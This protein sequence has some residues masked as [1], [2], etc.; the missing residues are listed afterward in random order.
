MRHHLSIVSLL[1]VSATP[2]TLASQGHAYHVARR[3]A[4]PGD[5]FWDYLTIDTASRRLYVTHGTRVQVLDVD[6][7]TVIG[8]IPNTPGVHDVALAPELGRGFTSNGRAAS[9]TIF[10]LKTL[11]IIGTVAVPGG[12]P[13][14]IVYDSVSRRVFTFNGRSRTATAIDAASGAVNG[15]LSLGG[16]PEFAVADGAG[17]IYV[18]IE[19]RNELSVIDSRAFTLLD[20]WPLPGCEEPTA[21]ALDRVH[22]RLFVGC[23]NERMVVVAAESGRVVA[24]VPIG[25][26]VDGVAFDPATQLVF[27]SNGEGTLTVIAESRDSCRVVATVPTARGARTLALDGR[28][29]HV[30]VVTAERTPP[31]PATEMNPN[32]R[33]GI[34]PG[35]FVVLEV[36]P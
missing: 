24:T 18:D 11:A 1:V 17:R 16:K 8:E 27:S 6:R 31:P 34:V 7:G 3:F 4:V 12:N 2:C 22:R 19:D 35:S 20:R 25:A 21:L 32:P 28:T 13:D 5:G 23:G 30:W 15:S 26:G 29:H 10:D 36:S 14:A 9:V 33:P